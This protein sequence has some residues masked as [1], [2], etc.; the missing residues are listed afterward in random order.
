MLNSSLERA[1]TILAANVSTN[2]AA[3][4][5]GCYTTFD[6]LPYSSEVWN[7]LEKEPVS[8]SKA[9]LME[10]EFKAAWTAPPEQ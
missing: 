10:E 8:I 5:F 2:Y 9:A 6:N 7:E 4:M 1:F 3:S